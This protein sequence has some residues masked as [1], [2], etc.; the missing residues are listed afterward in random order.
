MF[1]LFLLNNSSYLSRRKQMNTFFFLSTLIYLCVYPLIRFILSFHICL[2][3]RTKGEKIE[4]M[5]SP[6]DEKQMRRQIFA[7][8]LNISRANVPMSPCK[9]L[10]GCSEN[11]LHHC[12]PMDWKT[13]LLQFCPNY[14]IFEVVKTSEL[15]STGSRFG[16]S[17]CWENIHSYCFTS[18]L[19][20]V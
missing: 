9:D 20:A 8:S 14:A 2:H 5:Q 18:T 3:V 19:R 17:R 7:I 10:T 4:V 6:C 16:S 15:D 13:W 1:F 12:G 11:N